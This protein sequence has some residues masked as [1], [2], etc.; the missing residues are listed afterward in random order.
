MENRMNQYEE[1]MIEVVEFEV[2]DVIQ[3]SGLNLFN[4]NGDDFNWM[5]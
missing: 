3:T 4:L 5:E 1:P 2:E